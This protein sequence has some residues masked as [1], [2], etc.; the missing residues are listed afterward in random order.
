MLA[1]ELKNAL[2][3]GALDKYGNI[4]SDTDK[5]AKR[6]LSAIDSFVCAYGEGREIFVLSVPGR[7]EIIGNHTDH[8]G[9]KV[10]AGAID[11]D[12]IAIAAKNDDGVIRFHSEGYP[13]D[14][15]KLSEIANKEN[16]KK[17]SSASLIAGMCEGFLRS[18]YE[19]G[20]FDAYSTTEV[21]KGSGLSSSAAFEVMIGNALNHL[22]NGGRVENKRIAELAQFAKRTGYGR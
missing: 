21:L 6:F 22:Y 1:N 7:S 19:I 20:G 12:I 10:I 15:V 11:R 2:L 4:Y 17:Y 9:G 3:D 13:E 14:T 16:Y 18:G 8:N 5:E